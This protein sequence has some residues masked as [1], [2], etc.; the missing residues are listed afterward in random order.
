M[1]DTC[2]VQLDVVLF[3]PPVLQMGKPKTVS[4]GS[5]LE[6]VPDL[7]FSKASVIALQGSFSPFPLELISWGKKELLTNVAEEWHITK[8]HRL[9]L[10]IEY[11]CVRESK[12]WRDRESQ[13]E[14]A[15][16]QKTQKNRERKEVWTG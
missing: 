15:E 11:V 1:P 9:N 12:V 4:H 14:I 16:P 13:R 8:I 3:Y 10:D 2:Q 6:A 5:W 7:D